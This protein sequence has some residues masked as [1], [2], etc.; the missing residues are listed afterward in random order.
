MATVLLFM[1]QN[2]T[3]R[4]VMSKEHKLRKGSGVHLDMAV[5]SFVTGEKR[6]KSCITGLNPFIYSYSL[7]FCTRHALDGSRHRSLYGACA[8]PYKQ[9]R[10]RGWVTADSECARTT[11]LW[12]VHSYSYRSSHD[13][14]QATA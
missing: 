7:I 6:A 11:S 9:G 12:P 13:I 5:I 2:I 14:L 4:L 1:D 8:V 3:V 10:N